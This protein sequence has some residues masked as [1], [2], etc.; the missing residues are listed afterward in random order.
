M[1]RVFMVLLLVPT[2]LPAPG[3]AQADKQ[4]TTWSPFTFFLGTWKGEGHGRPG[5]SQLEREYR[6]ILNDRYIQVRH[7][8]VYAP[9][10]KNPKGETHEDMGILSYDR[11]RKVYV[12]RQFHVEGFVNQYRVEGVTEGGK[13]L[14]FITESIE[15]IPPGW[16]A[17]E[18]YKI[19]GADEFVEVFELAAPGKEFEKYSENRFR[20]Q[21]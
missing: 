15:N 6:L 9:Q 18:T 11:G 20:R 16:R 1:R 10:E 4:A 8:S 13:V 5:V 7:K 19:L 12:F 14:V 2:L 21:K 17:R 3:W